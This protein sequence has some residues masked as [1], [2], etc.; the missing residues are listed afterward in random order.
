M[1]SE[2]DIIKEKEKKQEEEK[3]KRIDKFL[4]TTNT[5]KTPY[6]QEKEEEF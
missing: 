4:G 5:D 3:R 1:Y 6:V 2:E